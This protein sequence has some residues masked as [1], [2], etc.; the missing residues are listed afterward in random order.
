MTADLHAQGF[1]V[2]HGI[3]FYVDATIESPT[4]RFALDTW[5]VCFTV[6]R[7]R[8]FVQFPRFDATGAKVFGATI[9]VDH[10]PEIARNGIRAD[11][12]R[13]LLAP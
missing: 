3:V 4:R 13:A 6:D 5:G 12:F 7:G 10:E 1:H 9:A 11:L 2:R 8:I